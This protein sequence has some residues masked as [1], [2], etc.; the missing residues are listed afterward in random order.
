[1]RAAMKAD[2]V[3]RNRVHGLG[4]NHS[5]T[6][7]RTRALRLFPYISRS[8]VLQVGQATLAGLRLLM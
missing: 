5:H 6:I 2:K 8:A 1:M 4:I 3:R 7:L